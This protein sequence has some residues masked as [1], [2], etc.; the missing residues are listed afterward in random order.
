MPFVLSNAPN[1][2][3]IF[4]HQVLRPFMGKIMVVY[5]NDILIYSPSLTLHLELLRA[6]F[7]TL[8]VEPLYINRKKCTFFSNVVMFLGFVVSTNGVH[9]NQFKVDAILNWPAPRTMH[10]VMSFHGLASFYGRFIQNFRTIIDLLT[11][12]LKGRT[13]QWTAEA[14][15]SFQLIK[16]K[17]TEATILTLPDFEQVFEVNCDASGIGIGG[18]LS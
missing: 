13:F 5:F 16:Q 3:M 14:E 4:M 17:M 11:D 8:R 7:E 2:F 10:D 1:T 6:I 15:A 18:V 9:A 12:C